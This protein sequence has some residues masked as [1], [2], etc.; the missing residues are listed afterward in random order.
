M[1]LT[2]QQIDLL[3]EQQ[4][5]QVLT[6]QKQMVSPGLLLVDTCA[7]KASAVHCQRIM[8]DEMSCLQRGQSS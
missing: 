2:P 8:T 7:L 6:L 5:L 3:P 1:N 4:K